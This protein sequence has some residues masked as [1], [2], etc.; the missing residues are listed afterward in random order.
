MIDTIINNRTRL[1]QKLA[2]ALSSVAPTI[3][4]SAITIPAMFIFQFASSPENR[5]FW[6]T[7]EGIVIIIIVSGLYAGGLWIS[8]KM[9][10]GVENA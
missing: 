7:L 1:N 6:F 4:V 5:D 3:W 9:V 2:T 10:K 8:K